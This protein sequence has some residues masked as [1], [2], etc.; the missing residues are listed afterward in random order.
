MRKK[1]LIVTT[2]ASMIQ[3][4]CIPLISLLNDMDYDVEVACNF[5]SGNN[6]SNEKIEQF[7]QELTSEGVKYYHVSFSRKLVD[8][9]NVE[10]Y[11]YLVK[12]VKEEGYDFIHCH[13]PIA[14][15]ISRLVGHKTKTKVMYTAHGFHFFTGAPLK[16]WLLYY[17]A[18]WIASFMTH[19][20]ITINNEDYHRAQKHMHAKEVKYIPGV[21]IDLNKFGKAQIDKKSK[22]EELNI[23]SDCTLLLSVG[24]MNKNKNHQRIIN[25]MK[26]LP[27]DIHYAIVGIDH[28]DGYNQKLVESLGLGDRV[29]F[30]GY[31]QDVSE[32]YAA[33]DVF[34]FPSYREGLSV[35]LMEAMATGLPCVVSN[36]RGNCDLIN[37]T[38]GSLFD[39]SSDSSCLQ[40]IQTVLS[41][42]RVAY[43][44]A[45]QEFIQNFSSKKVQNLM[46]E[47]YLEISSK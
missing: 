5:L 37:D 4:F 38:R 29:H 47:Y 9:A 13:T 27:S 6:I 30:L 20:L 15:F 40:A 26:D 44:K 43:Q 14:G 28:L 11:Q 42:D 35:S 7:K 25:I 16:N 24:E 45:N 39:P 19:T 41:N 32:I 12:L 46:R 34:V 18:E 2:T 33:S 17:P 10:S 23:P 21:G 8:R 1:V 31:R 36:I 22:R 3:N